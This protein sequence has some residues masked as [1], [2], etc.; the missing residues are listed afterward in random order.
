MTDR[1]RNLS[2][3]AVASMT[4]VGCGNVATPPQAFH[5]EPVKKASLTVTR[6][7]IGTVM[8]AI[9]RKV[10]F[11]QTLAMV[12][13]VDVKP[14]TMVQVGQPLVGLSSGASVAAP[15]AGKIVGVVSKGTPVG[16][17]PA[18]LP[19]AG[20][21]QA[22]VA[23]IA[24]L[25]PLTIQVPVPLAEVAAWK[26]GE[27]ATI[28]QHGKILKGTVT[29]LG[30]KS[31]GVRRVT[32][33]IPSGPALTLGTLKD[34]TVHVRRIASAWVVP[35]SAIEPISSGRG[36]QVQTKE[37]RRIFVGI[38]AVMPNFV[39]VKGRL[40]GGEMLRVPSTLGAKGLHPPLGL[41]P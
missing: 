12:Q 5:V 19:G 31:H 40:Y 27:V 6:Q 10:T 13:S 35:A 14:G 26:L 4:V 9:I 33:T 1:L 25:H 39:A 29:Q 37:G 17:A 18:G 41:M 15:Y 36:D 23:E 32:V 38:V 28:V 20:S 22:T 3:G 7:W 8:P 30:T 16:E 24:V 2:L 21:G 34:V 11:N